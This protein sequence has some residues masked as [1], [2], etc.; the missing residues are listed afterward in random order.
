M[1]IRTLLE[2]AGLRHRRPHH[3]HDDLWP[4]EQ[5]IPGSHPLVPEA[6][7]HAVD[8]FGAPDAWLHRIQ[9]DDGIEWWLMHEEHGLLES[10]SLTDERP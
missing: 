8:A 6:I 1:A 10:F 5:P 2:F 3:T 7:R 9:T 4:E